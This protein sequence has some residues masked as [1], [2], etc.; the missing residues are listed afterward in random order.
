MGHGHGRTS[1]ERGAVSSAELS[2]DRD[3]NPDELARLAEIDADLLAMCERVDA[4]LRE[5]HPD[6]FDE[7]GHLDLVA[8]SQLLIARSGNESPLSG[9]ALPELKCS[10]RLVRTTVR[11]D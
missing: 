7:Q 11:P 8:A 10:A 2:D 6:L 9:R 1:R 4:Q 5:R 3:L